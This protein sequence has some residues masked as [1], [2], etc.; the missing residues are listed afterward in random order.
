MFYSKGVKVHPMVVLLSVLGGLA[1]FGL[2]GFIY[3][4]VIV[5][6]FVAMMT[7]YKEQTRSNA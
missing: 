1:T 5:S 3:G 4:P 7:V 2:L 6:V